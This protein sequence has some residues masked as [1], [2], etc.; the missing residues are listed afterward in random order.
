MRI[1]DLDTNRGDDC[2]SGWTRIST[3]VAACIAPSSNP[4]FILLISPLLVLHIAKYVEGHWVIRA[5]MLMDFAYN[6]LLKY[7]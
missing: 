7:M 5:V 6:Q 4:G 2:P 3:P 1:A